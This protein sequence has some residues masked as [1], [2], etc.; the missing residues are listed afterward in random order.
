VGGL[1]PATWTVEKRP[2]FCMLR[3]SAR[4]SFVIGM[5]V[6]PRRARDAF[7]RCEQT[8][9]RLTYTIWRET[10]RGTEIVW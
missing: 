2:C 5:E 4:C 7:W 9:L 1:R 3:H 8:L 6:R 10:R